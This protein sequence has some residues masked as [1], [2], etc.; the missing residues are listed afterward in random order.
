M[1]NIESLLVEIRDLLI[2]M[3]KQKESKKRKS[4]AEA[5][6]LYTPDFEDT[7]RHYPKKVNKRQAGKVWYK[8]VMRCAAADPTQNWPKKILIAVKAYEE[9]WPPS[10]IKSEGKYCL[11]LSTF[12]NQDRFEDDPNAWPKEDTNGE[13][14]GP[15]WEPTV[16]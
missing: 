10:R 12:L 2:E 11:H 14:G 16:D 7:W 6:D 15:A 8:T 9:V 4:K 1:N 13:F 5:L 3:T